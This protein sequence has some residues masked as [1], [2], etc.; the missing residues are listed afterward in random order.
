MC[1][2][3]NQE[4]SLVVVNSIN[5]NNQEII[6]R[7]IGKYQ[8]STKNAVESILNM[9]EAVYEVY[10]KSKSGE[11]SDVD[12]TNFCNSVHLDPKG[13][14]FRKYKAIGQNADRLRE[15]MHKLPSTFSVI[16]E[17]ATLSRDDFEL[18][19]IRSTLSKNT[20]LEEFKNILRR[21]AMLAN[22]KLCNPPRLPT[23]SAMLAKAM[24]KM[25]RFSISVVR[26][27]PE[28]QF[29]EIARILADLR[30][31]GWIEFDSP[32]IRQHLEDLIE[33]AS[34][35]SSSELLK[36]NERGSHL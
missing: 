18:L 14:S 34:D 7:L 35:Q 20:T 2:S 9:G 13:S 3:E 17:M 12:L 30:N 27:I 33:N 22:N 16:Y 6:E 23:T 19:V 15:C 26:D 8:F 11:L 1:E 24:K 36:E 29:E 10:T 31:R 32:T 4:Y 28:S 5:E 21:K 25:N